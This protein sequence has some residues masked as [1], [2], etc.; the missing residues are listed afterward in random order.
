M[1]FCEICEKEHFLVHKLS[2]RPLK[3]CSKKCAIK[4]CN[5]NRFNN[6]VI[7]AKHCADG[8]KRY[9]KKHG[10]KSEKDFRCAPKGSGCITKYGYKRLIKHGHPNAATCGAIFE[11][12]FIMSEHLGRPLHKEE[13]IHHKNGV[14]LDNRIENLEIWTISQPYGQRLEDKLSWAKEIL[15]KY[16]HEVIM[17]GVVR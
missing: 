4:K 11:H 1:V 5:L 15:E 16:G 10:I 7:R 13:R 17:K 12:T 2:G 9:W 14:K 6:K 3:Y 8:R